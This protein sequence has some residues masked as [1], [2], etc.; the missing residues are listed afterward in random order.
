MEV[1]KNIKDRIKWFFHS[2]K[3][4]L[5]PSL[6]GRGWG[7]GL[8]CLIL[9]SCVTDDFEYEKKYQCY[10]TF[11]CGIHQG[12]TLQNCLNPISP[13]VFCMVWSQYSG[14]VNHI[15]IQLYNKQAED[16]AITTDIERRRSCVLGANN[17]LVIGCSTLYEGQLYAFDRQ[18][19]NCA[20]NGTLKPLQW[21]NN[22]LWL[23]CPKCER[24]YDLNNNGFIVKG[25]S[26]DKLMR[27]RASYDGK[28]LLITN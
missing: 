6:Y 22:G 27:Y 18:C 4:Y 26:G 20:N 19:P 21:E 23:K 11:D 8:V 15:Q 10:F 3:R 17:G 2:K 25:E 24:V 12:T 9:F 14:G 7:V 28:V 13:G 1:Q 16:V 5:L